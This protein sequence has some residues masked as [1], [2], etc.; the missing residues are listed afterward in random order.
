MMPYSRANAII[1]LTDAGPTVRMSAVFVYM[2]VN[3]RSRGDPT[4]SVHACPLRSA[5][6]P[7]DH[8]Y[9]GLGA[10]TVRLWQFLEQR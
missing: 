6:F 2:Q 9:G 5:C 3:L 1:V 4:L 10:R 8:K 7:F